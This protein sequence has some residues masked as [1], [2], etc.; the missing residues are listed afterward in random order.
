MESVMKWKLWKHFKSQEIIVCWSLMPSKW[1]CHLLVSFL[2][3]SQHFHCQ[4]VLEQECPPPEELCWRSLSL[5]EVEY[6]HS[7]LRWSSPGT[8]TRCCS[9]ALSWGSWTGAPRTGVWWWCW[10]CPGCW[11]LASYGGWWAGILQHQ[12]CWDTLCWS[13]PLWSHWLC[14]TWVCEVQFSCNISS[15]KIFMWYGEPPEK[16][17]LFTGLAP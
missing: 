8:W 3:Y 5:R 15:L 4:T 2:N 12:H 6:Q 1:C 13:C 11:S 16:F 17:P 7:F 14:P 10:S 9:R